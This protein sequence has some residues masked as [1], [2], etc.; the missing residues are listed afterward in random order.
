MKRASVCFVIAS[1]LA[2]L[3]LPP[4]DAGAQGDEPAAAAAAEPEAAPPAGGAAAPSEGTA[5]AGQPVATPTYGGLSLGTIKPPTAEEEAALKELAEDI[6]IYN[7]NAE[8]FKEAIKNIIKREYEKRKKQ[9]EEELSK[10]IEEEE[11]LE[12]EARR[13][14]IEYFEAFLVKYPDNDEFTP[15]A[16][17]RLSELYYE[18]SYVE[19]LKAYDEYTEQRKL[20]KQNKIAEEPVEPKRDFSKTID[21]YEKLIERYP[22]YR[23]IDGVYYLLGFC[24]NEMGKF[25]QALLVWLSYVC[26]NQYAYADVKAKLEAM[27][28]AATAAEEGVDEEH[29][30]TTLTDVS[31]AGTKEEEA[32]FAVKAENTY[33]DCAPLM[34][35][36]RFFTETWL[37][38]GEYHFDFDYSK[39]GLSNAISAYTK[40]LEDPTST[41]YDLALYKLAWSYW[42][43]GNYTDAI[44]NFIQ[45]IEY[46]DKKAAETG[47]SGS[48]LR[49]EAIQYIAL[50]LWE[51]DWDGDNTPDAVSGFDRLKDPTIIPQDRPWTPEVYAWLGDVYMDDNANLKAIEV[52]EETLKRW[53]NASEAPDIIVKI[54]KAYQREKM[55]K[56]VIETR[57]R[58]AEYGKDSTWWNANMDKPELQEKALI[59]AEDAL[60]QT[61]IHHHEVA[62]SLKTTAKTKTNPDEQ[63]ELYQRAV[64]EYNLAATAYQKYLEAYPN[65]PDAYEMHFFLAETYFWSK[66]Y[67]KSIPVY[68]EVRDSQM[69]NKYQKDAAFMVVKAVEQVRDD[70]VAKGTLV[71]RE[72]PPDPVKGAGG[73]PVVSPEP[74]PSVLTKYVESMDL[75]VKL[76]PADTKNAPVFVYNAAELYYNY[77]QWDEAKARFQGIYDAYCKKDNISIYSWQNMSSMAGKLDQVEEAEKLA[78]LQD[79][80]KCGV[81]GSAKD[82]KDLLTKVDQT[83]KDIKGT[84]E[85]R[86]AMDA[87]Y[88]AE[89]TGDVA[90][91]DKAAEAL[92]AVVTKNPKHEDADKMLWNAAIS[93][94]KANKFASALRVSQR[95]IDEYPQSEFMGDA[96]DKLADNA[97]HAFEY[98]KALTNYQLLA[99]EPR[100]KDSPHRKPAVQ[101]VALILENQQKYKDAAKY[102]KKYSEMESDQ[103]LSMAAQWNAAKA[104]EKG[105]MWSNV[106]SEMT[107][108][109][110]RFAGNGDAADEVV[111]ANWAIAEAY[112]KQGKKKEYEK[113]LAAV[114]GRYNS[115]KANLDPGSI[116]IDHAAE[117]KFVLVEAG[118]SKVETFK[119]NTNNEKKVT[120]DLKTLKEMRDALIAQ[121][122]Q[123]V[124]MASPEWS[125]AAQFRIGY[126]Y[127][128]HSKIL[129]EAPIPKS[130][131]KLGAEMEELYRQKIN[132][133]VF[134]LEDQC[135]VEYAKA[136]QLSKAGG[137]FNKWTELTLERL[138]AYDPDNYPIYKKGKTKSIE[139][140]FGY[141][142]F[143]TK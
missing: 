57:A 141:A 99:D 127:E 86:K 98:D 84:A 104:Y 133:I 44:A 28:A 18:E 103:K 46:S 74:M 25:D 90:L 75:Y 107:A 113:A 29:P 100:F 115:V 11:R 140:S 27:E 30:S 136:Y 12:D 125:V 134:P 83:I 82:E 45:V 14:A 7:K 116:A 23:N 38:V 143:D 1:C 121:Y 76:F 122:V 96:L 79:E 15:D 124:N 81:E 22:A 131:T 128:T 142:T 5:A 108:F 80:K 64:E 129:L 70:E 51:T 56:E 89:K 130:V 101:N 87:F 132:D 43:N 34:K 32:I 13:S 9:I 58:L 6:E 63:N 88:E 67:E 61:A 114:I 137:I 92:E 42:R 97:F 118:L 52:F 48:E 53:P 26:A 59:A 71:V 72:T 16:M 68:E 102:W 119:L 41:F 69:D 139:E 35:D 47:K 39:L 106:V 31:T 78:L 4:G 135:K 8:D 62:Q 123:V 33:K 126:L 120:D 94:E 95:I 91:Y 24:L 112:K 65:S 54:A 2:V 85:V 36:S 17:F 55:E 20:F 77:G 66:Q 109:D 110:K 105:K 3:G 49:P 37:R 138:N 50:S 40:A 111:E 93:Y 10:Q 117:A 73:K 19:H 21:I 60:K